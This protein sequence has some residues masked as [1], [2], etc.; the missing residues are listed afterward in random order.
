MNLDRLL[1]KDDEEISLLWGLEPLLVRMSNDGFNGGER[2][3]D[4]P[5]VWR[6]MSQGGTLLIKNHEDMPA[7]V[8]I[9]GS[10]FASGTPRRVEARDEDGTILASTSVPIVLS[11]FRLGPFDVPAGTSRIT[12]AATPGPTPFGDKR[13]RFGSIFLSPLRA[14]A[15]TR[16]HE[17]S[18]GAMK[19]PSGNSAQRKQGRFSRSIGQ[20]NATE[21]HIRTLRVRALRELVDLVGFDIVSV[22]PTYVWRFP[23]DLVMSRFSRS[24]AAT[25]SSFSGA[26]LLRSA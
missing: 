21:G 20:D 5:G 9:E 15:G 14:P 3:L 11:E 24:L 12:L 23:P 10:A 7:T 25:A 17:A 4:Y 8:T 2:Y 16:L 26:D 13:H 22:T 6:W 1:A 18:L 19:T